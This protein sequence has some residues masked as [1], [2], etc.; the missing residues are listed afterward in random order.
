[1][2]HNFVQWGDCCFC[3]V[4]LPAH[5]DRYRVDVAKFKT[6]EYRSSASV[7][8]NSRTNEWFLSNSVNNG[9]WT[10][11][12]E[13]PKHWRAVIILARNASRDDAMRSWIALQIRATTKRKKVTT[14]FHSIHLAHFSNLLFAPRV[15]S[16]SIHHHKIVH[17]YIILP[18]LRA[19]FLFYL[20]YGG[21]LYA[22]TCIWRIF[23]CCR[24]C[25]LRI[26][27]MP[28]Y[29]AFHGDASS[30]FHRFLHCIR[31]AQRQRI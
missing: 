16:R 6:C 20:I 10:N 22:H 7:F 13:N 28:K 9:D 24:K 31:I 11:A 25:W 1:M 2:Q 21:I 23:F 15:S 17:I 14:I 18:L 8:T 30:S 19:Q 3:R 29:S 12:N 27:A 26:F 5:V 4:K